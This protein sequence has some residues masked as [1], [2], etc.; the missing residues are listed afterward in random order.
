MKIKFHIWKIDCW[1]IHVVVPISCRLFFFF[2]GSLSWH[3]KCWRLGILLW[4]G[5]IIT[6]LLSL[7]RRRELT[8]SSSSID[9]N[10]HRWKNEHALILRY[11]EIK[12]SLFLLAEQI[13]WI[14]SNERWWWRY[15]V[16]FWAE[17]EIKS[18]RLCYENEFDML[19]QFVRR[20]WNVGRA[21][22]N[23]DYDVSSGE[24]EVKQFLWRS[25]RFIFI[26]KKGRPSAKKR[27]GI[28]KWKNLMS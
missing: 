4:L 21:Q 11:S 5:P 15:C 22:S 28:E 20:E 2:F 12:I 27:N 9:R 25:T 13:L 26:A 16:T 7:N 14:E 1:N 10:C 19:S 17:S 24:R 8:T 23:A 3:S 6:L 18:I